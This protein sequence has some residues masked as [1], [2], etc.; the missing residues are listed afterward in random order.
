MSYLRQNRALPELYHFSWNGLE[1]IGL[2][3]VFAPKIF[4]DSFFFAESL[5]SIET[6]HFLEIGCGTGLISVHKALQG[7][8]VTAS[9]VNPDAVRN[10]RMNSILHG[11]DDLV[12][13]VVSDVFEKIDNLTA[14]D[15]MFWNIPFQFSESPVTDMLERSCFS[16]GYDDIRTFFEGAKVIISS[17][18]R[19]LFG[20]SADSGDSSKLDECLASLRLCKVCISQRN[21]S[22]PSESPFRVGL[23][24]VRVQ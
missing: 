3:S 11:V 14:F 24:E 5:T 17:G 22:K 7:S 13:C 19:A 16:F 1:F 2:N 6:R 23:Y 21:L 15:C 9:D 10:T 4:E 18:G 8:R 12:T 20:Y